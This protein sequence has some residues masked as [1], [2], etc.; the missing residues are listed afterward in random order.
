MYSY[1]GIGRIF[2]FIAFIVILFII[3]H[4]TWYIIEYIIEYI[5]KKYKKSNTDSIN[6]DNNI[7]TMETATTESL[8]ITCPACGTS[9]SRY[10]NT[11]IKCGHPI[12]EPQQ[13]VIVQQSKSNGVGTA[14]FVLALISL[15]L[16]WV[17]GVGWFVWFL[18]FLLSFIGMF[19]SPKTLA[20]FGFFISIIDFIIL[21][22]VVGTV[23]GTLF[24]IFG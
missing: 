23:A 8:M 16:S 5:I 3:F 6:D 1:L 11:C 22:V 9:I 20:V 15:V 18:G 21:I 4:I 12:Q 24:S 14:G 17:P 7:E 10:A 2:F 13:T 19:K